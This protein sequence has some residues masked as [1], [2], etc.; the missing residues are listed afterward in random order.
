M[1]L[2]GIKVSEAKPSDRERKLSDGG[3]LYLLIKPN[4]TKTW[5]Y[6]YRFNGKELTLAIGLYPEVSLKLARQRH[7]AARELLASGVD[8]NQDKRDQK[9]AAELAA[10]NTFGMVAEEWA[11]VRLSGLTDATIE[12]NTS[13]VSSEQIL[14][15]KNP[16]QSGVPRGSCNNA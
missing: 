15:T 9:L 11:A 16:T 5:R 2:T 13:V 4:G 6:K 12:R 1:K 3:G 7:K 14:L 10:G 8:P